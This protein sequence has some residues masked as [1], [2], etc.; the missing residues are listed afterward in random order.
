MGH[1]KKSKFH[2]GILV[3]TESSLFVFVLI[4]PRPRIF[5]KGILPIS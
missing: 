3:F 4:M 2:A 1:S 5:L